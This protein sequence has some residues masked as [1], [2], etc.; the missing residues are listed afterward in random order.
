VEGACRLATTLHGR[1]P[2]LPTA[3]A[4]PSGRGRL[5]DPRRGA[6]REAGVDEPAGV[7]LPY[8][9]AVMPGGAEA[10]DL[11]VRNRASVFWSP[12]HRSVPQGAPQRHSPPPGDAPSSALAW[13]PSRLGSAASRLHEPRDCCHV[14]KV[15]GNSSSPSPGEGRSGDPGRGAAPGSPRSHGRPP[16]HSG[17]Q[18]PRHP[19]SAAPGARSARAGSGWK[20]KRRGPPQHPHKDF[21]FLGRDPG[22]V[23]MGPKCRERF[24]L[25]VFP[26]S[27]SWNV[28]KAEAWLS[29]LL[30]NFP[31]HRNPERGS[32]VCRLTAR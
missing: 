30:S 13:V 15:L 14:E 22:E 9:G 24:F 32:G 20:G 25:P 8:P 11:R 17:Q 6:A 21:E 18:S 2:A 10:L 19:D 31:Q 12:G 3:D 5:R 26:S 7:L 27:V 16:G 1:V 4:R 28:L 29:R 23:Q